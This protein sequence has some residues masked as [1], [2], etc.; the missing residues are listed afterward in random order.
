MYLNQ[1]TTDP[2]GTNVVVWAHEALVAEADDAA[3]AAH[4]VHA[5]VLLAH[6][7]VGDGGLAFALFVGQRDVQ[8]VRR[9]LQTFT[10]M[11][12]VLRDHPLITPTGGGGWYKSGQKH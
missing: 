9:L 8:L 3:V 6:E 11:S 7:A 5:G 2:P 10:D 12:I 1:P 4:A